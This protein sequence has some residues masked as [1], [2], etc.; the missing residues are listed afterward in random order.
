MDYVLVLAF[1]QGFSVYVTPAKGWFKAAEFESSV[2]TLLSSLESVQGQPLS[3]P[4]LLLWL[5][6]SALS[7]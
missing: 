1:Q 2:D 4:V 6:A 3:T 7:S 5:P